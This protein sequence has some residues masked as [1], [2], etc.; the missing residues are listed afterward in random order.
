MYLGIILG[1][2]SFDFVGGYVVGARCP[3][4]EIL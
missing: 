3:I 1:K 4:E 2:D